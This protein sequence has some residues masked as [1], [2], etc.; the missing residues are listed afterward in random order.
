MSLN[1]KVNN[2]QQLLDD[3]KK[4]LTEVTN[5]GDA[6]AYSI[7]KNLHD[8][9]D[10]LVANWKGPDAGVQIN[11][12]VTVYNGMVEFRLKMAD[13]AISAYSVGIYYRN[14]QSANGA[15]VDVPS[16]LSDDISPNTESPYEDNRD[17][18]D[19]TPEAMEGK[20]N[21]DKANNSFGELENNFRELMNS[22]FG[23]W[24]AGDRRSDF[25]EYFRDFSS[26]FSN[27]Q[28]LLNNI[29]K[30]ITSALE[31]YNG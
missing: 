7:I 25:E 27:Y 14:I 17:T 20:N 23:N 24:T 2:V 19:I 11:N 18:I 12:L 26:K 9:Y 21:I 29:T 6:S 30:N 1:H 16:P 3:S 10:N 22:I 4:L 15:G 31:N 5:G 8:A 13:L 28:E